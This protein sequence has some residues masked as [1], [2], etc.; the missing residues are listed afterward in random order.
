MVKKTMEAYLKK[1]GTNIWGLG[2]TQDQQT[3]TI[4]VKNFKGSCFKLLKEDYRMRYASILLLIFLETF[5]K[6]IPQMV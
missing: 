1:K 2:Q 4:F 3:G 5:H 6:A